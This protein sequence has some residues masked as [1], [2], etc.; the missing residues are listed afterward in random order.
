VE[1]KQKEPWNP[2]SLGER[3]VELL[4]VEDGDV[5]EVIKT[6][7]GDVMVKKINADEPTAN[8]T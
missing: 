6:R 3:I 1:K 4:G 7:G 5:I 2:T 8:D